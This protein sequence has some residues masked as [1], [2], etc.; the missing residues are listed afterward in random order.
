MAISASSSR[1]NRQR[2]QLLL[3]VRRTHRRWPPFLPF[4]ST[5]RRNIVFRW[6][7]IAL[8]FIAILPPLFFHFKLRRFHQMQFRR[9]RWL[10]NPPLVCAHGGDSSKAFPNT[11]DAYQTA[12]RSQVD[13]IEIDVS[14]S[15]DGGLFALH[16]RDLQRILGNST[17]R[18]GYLST[19]EIQELVPNQH[20]AMKFHDLSIPTIEDAL[21]LEKTVCKS[22]LVWAKS[23]TLA[24]DLIKLS[25]DVT[26][27]YIVMIN[28]STGTR[29]NLLRMRGAEVV[30]VYHPLVDEKLVK[31]LHGRKKKVYAWTVD[32]EISMQK[33]LFEHVDAVVTSN[34]TLF[35]RV[36]QNMRTECLEEGF[37]LSS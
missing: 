34:P 27:G 29:M 31:I 9:C 25:S 8:A 20:L 36:M 1:W 22:C 23:D 6:L 30:G 11:M 7:L 2:P 26:V 16:D 21:K 37:S 3:G 18:V 32:D 19:K 15:L 24:R 14:R 33:M 28:P 35:Q 4:P 5:I 10:R 17:S 12:L 13:C